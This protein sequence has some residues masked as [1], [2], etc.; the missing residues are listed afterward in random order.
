MEN[1]INLAFG[2][3]LSAPFSLSVQTMGENIQ[4]R[5][6][7]FIF[8]LSSSNIQ[9]RIIFRATKASVCETTQKKKNKHVDAKIVDFVFD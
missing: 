4:I 9:T 7:F 2:V 6:L 5:R 3:C 1:L 8:F